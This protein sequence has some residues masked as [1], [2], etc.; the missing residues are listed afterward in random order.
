[1][2]IRCRRNSA[3]FVSFSR[4]SSSSWTRTEPDVGR[5]NPAIMF[6]RVDLPQPDGPI[7]ATASPVRIS[8][9]TPSRAVVSPYSLRTLSSRTTQV[10][11]VMAARYGRG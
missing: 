8:S 11:V 2:P 7:T 9:D 10:S 5:S 4:P 1:M 3:S 6:S